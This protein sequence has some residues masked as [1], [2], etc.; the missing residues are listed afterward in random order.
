MVRPKLNHHPGG[1]AAEA[2]ACRV[3]TRDAEHKK[4]KGKSREPARRRRYQGEKPA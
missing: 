2:Q 3:S 4:I 1:G